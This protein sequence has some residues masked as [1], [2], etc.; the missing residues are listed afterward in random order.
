M[1]KMSIS[2]FQLLK[3]TIVIGAIVNHKT[4]IDYITVGRSLRLTICRSTPAHA[5]IF[6]SLSGKMKL[7]VTKY[8]TSMKNKSNH[9]SRKLN[10]DI[11]KL[12]VVTFMFLDSR[13]FYIINGS[14]FVIFCE[15]T[16]DVDCIQLEL[17]II[18]KSDII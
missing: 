13:S 12:L 10:D 3:I 14:S 2:Y 1:L 4:P 11:T 17:F 5:T 18:K 7:K 15:F 6:V 16:I 8:P 9:A